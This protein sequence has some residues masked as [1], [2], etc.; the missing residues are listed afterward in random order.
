MIQNNRNSQNFNNSHVAYNRNSNIQQQMYRNSNI[1]PGVINN[2][3][4][5]TKPINSQISYQ[6]SSINNQNCY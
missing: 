6:N 3:S 4:V 5:L 2:E 1:L